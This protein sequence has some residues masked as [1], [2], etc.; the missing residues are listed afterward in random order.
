MQNI[1]KDDKLKQIYYDHTSSAYLGSVKALYN[2]VK[3]D[4][5]T[6]KD[7]KVW[8]DKQENNQLTSVPTSK[9]Y[10]PIVG[11]ANDYQA[12][13]MFLPTYKRQNDG[14][15]IILGF[16]ELTTRKVYAYKLKN[17]T[18]KTVSDAYQL[19]LNQIDGKLNNLTTDNGLEFDNKTFKGLDSKYK[20]NHHFVDAGDKT[21]DG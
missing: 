15:Y 8:M 19:F 14:Y 13:L 4:G 3:N 17:K 18:E 21:P 1:N 5:Y 20:V 12:D 2:L 7:V 11:E 10:P 9:Y 16:I 6:L